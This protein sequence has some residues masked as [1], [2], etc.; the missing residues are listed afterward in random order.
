M[1]SVVVKE[2]AATAVAQRPRASVGLY[3][4]NEGNFCLCYRLVSGGMKRTSGQFHVEQSKPEGGS[5]AKFP[6]VC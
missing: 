1:R 6:R 2:L 4:I 3:I 5:E